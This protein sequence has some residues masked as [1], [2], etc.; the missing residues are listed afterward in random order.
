[1]ASTRA[2]GATFNSH[3]SG[4]RKIDRERSSRTVRLARAGR[5]RRERAAEFE[6]ADVA[7]SIALI[8]SLVA[9]GRVRIVACIDSHASCLQRNRLCGTSIIHEAGRIEHRISIDLVAGGGQEAGAVIVAEIMALRSNGAGLVR[10]VSAICSRFENRV[11]DL[12]NG[13]ATGIVD[14][15]A[16]GT[17][18]V[19]IKGAILNGECRAATVA[20]G[21]DGAPILGGGVVIEGTIDKAAGRAPHEGVVLNGAAAYA[22]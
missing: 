19:P 9:F 11:G 8:I 18:G 15:T 4:K 10:K 21:A 13:A 16:T 14:T 22:R 2:A 1:M 6:G 12:E 3:R 7:Y 5:G 17:R 20:V